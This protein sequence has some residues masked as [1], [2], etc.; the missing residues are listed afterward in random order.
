[1]FQYFSVQRRSHYNNAV[2]RTHSR[3][4]SKNVGPFYFGFGFLVSK[5]Y[6]YNALQKSTSKIRNTV[7]KHECNTVYS[8]AFSSFY[9][10][11]LL[12]TRKNYNFEK[13]CEYIL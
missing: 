13:I 3:I 7:L 9:S 1:M 4:S 8:I 10:I 5:K 6:E 12:Q 2:I 11:R